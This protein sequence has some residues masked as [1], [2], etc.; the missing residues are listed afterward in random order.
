MVIKI[1]IDYFFP[2]LQKPLSKSLG[3]HGI[4]LIYW[5]KSRV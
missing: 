2:S 5:Q 1:T 4:G 3:I